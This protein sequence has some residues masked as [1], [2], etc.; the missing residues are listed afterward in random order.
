MPDFRADGFS[1]KDLE[2]AIREQLSARDRRLVDWL[3]FGTDT[4]HLSGH[5]YRAVSRQKSG[6]LKCY[7]D[8]D[9]KMRNAQVEFPFGKGRPGLREIHSRRDRV[10]QGGVS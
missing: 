7:F 8:M 4:S 1:Y 5:F 10:L 3:D 9:R 2:A 6:F